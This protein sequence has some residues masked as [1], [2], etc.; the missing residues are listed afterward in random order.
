MTTDAQGKVIPGLATE[1]QQSSDSLA[2]T[3]RPGVQFQDGTPFDAEAVEWN[4]RK[5]QNQPG[6]RATLGLVDRID[7]SR[8]DEVVL[9]LTRP[10]PD[11][12][13]QLASFAGLMVSPNVT[14]ADLEGGAPAGTGPYQ[15]DA[16][17]SQKN[18]TYVYRAFDE[19]NGPHAPLFRTVTGRV[20]SDDVSRT[21]ALRSG[22][23]D[24]GFLSASQVNDVD[25]RVGIES[26]RAYVQALVILDA[27]PGKPLGDPLV[28]EAIARA[29]DRDAFGKAVNF[30]RSYPQDV[31]L[32]SGLPGAID[33]YI[34]YSYDPERARRLI[35]DSGYT[36]IRLEIP[37]QGGF[38]LGGEA[39]ASMLEQVGVH[40][41][42]VPVAIGQD[43]AG[44]LAGKFNSTYTFVPD[45]DPE[46]LYAKFVS[47]RAPFNPF[48]ISDPDIEAAH[49]RALAAPEGQPEQDAAYED[50]LR[51]L[52]DSARIIPIARVESVFGYDESRL[53]DVHA[54]SGVPGF[55][56][57]ADLRPR[58]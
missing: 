49:A 32:E 12:V 50:M 54:W 52:Y 7:V 9:H 45:I 42:L 41:D 43:T 6:T 1:W 58:N 16:A 31:L 4:I 57:F 34:G 11:L 17:S 53:S 40:V 55:P 20:I 44:I 24:G 2:M 29:I 33:G 19:Y 25:G 39:L 47:P 26:A 38:R 48:K 13:T 46:S 5:Q 27:S 18:D 22:R 56:R 35:A 28:R 51:S 37:V 21:N 3:L 8:P 23:I 36:D 30:G 10:A 15:I 14:Q